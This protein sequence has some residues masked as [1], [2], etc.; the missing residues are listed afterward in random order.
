MLPRFQIKE[1]KVVLPT[2]PKSYYKS[3]FREFSDGT[4]VVLEM[5]D[6]SHE[7]VKYWLRTLT[8]D[9]QIQILKPQDSDIIYPRTGGACLPVFIRRGRIV[10]YKPE[11]YLGFFTVSNV[12][13]IAEGKKSFYRKP[14][15]DLKEDFK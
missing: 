2:A 9:T 6:L 14:T 10:V 13:D 1:E 5:P 7:G 15:T 8:P 3:T 12:S 11:K 4:M